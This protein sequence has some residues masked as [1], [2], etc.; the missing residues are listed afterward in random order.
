MPRES[1]RGKAIRELEQDAKK[2][3]KLYILSS[4]LEDDG[5]GETNEGDDDDHV[6]FVKL[7]VLYHAYQAAKRLRIARSCRYLFRHKKYRAYQG[8]NEFNVDLFQQWMNEEEFKRKYRC[9]R[10][11][12]WRIVSCIENHPV[13]S[14]GDGTKQQAP[15]SHQLLCL[16]HFLGMEGNGASNQ[17]AR[18]VFKKGVGT[19]QFYR[20]RC[21]KAIFD[22]LFRTTVTWPDEV[23]RK[24]ISKRIFERYGLPNCVGIADGTLFPLRFCPQTNDKG[25]YNGRKLGYTI[26]TLVVCDDQLLIR[27]F[28]SGWPGCTHD[29]RV[30]RNSALAKSPEDFF[31]HNE[32]LLG[33]SAYS[34]R[35]YMVPAYKKSPGE[36]EIPGDLQAFNT[37]LGSARVQSEHCIGVLKGRFPFLR[38]IRMK[39]TE[40]TQ[41]LRKILDYISVCVTL[42]NLLVVRPEDEIDYEDEE[43]FSDIDAENELNQP[44]QDIL[45]QTTRRTQLTNY[46]LEHNA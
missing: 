16:L 4:L 25:D 34:P 6:G 36:A 5:D 27:Y 1:K 22:C 10:K 35:N 8:V 33:D 17:Y 46:I 43:T 32:Y 41:T 20:D 28:L 45:P 13:F 24:E 15:V 29:D 23:E 42:H 11:S 44:V 39:L 21:V 40:D 37:V 26:S 19:H 12:F 9:S 18:D 3:M 2:K 7:V 30:F 31:H 14:S 38:S